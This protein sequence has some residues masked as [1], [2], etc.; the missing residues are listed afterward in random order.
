[1]QL[2]KC[3]VVFR[4]D[5]ANELRAEPSFFL[6]E[7]DQPPWIAAGSIGQVREGVP[8]EESLDLILPVAGAVYDPVLIYRPFL[9]PPIP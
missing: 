7:G 6:V 1:M 4:P 8:V 5:P 2:S 9:I 3:C